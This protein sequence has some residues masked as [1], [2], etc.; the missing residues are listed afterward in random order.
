MNSAADIRN[1]FERGLTLGAL[2]LA[3]LRRVFRG[4][5]QPEQ[6]FALATN[7]FQTCFPCQATNSFVDL[8]SENFWKAP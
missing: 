4:N 1:P 6:R 5:S 7:T 8:S 2:S 3:R